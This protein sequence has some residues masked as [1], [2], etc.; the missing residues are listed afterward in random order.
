[1][2]NRFVNLFDGENWPKRCVGH[3]SFEWGSKYIY[4]SAPGSR[5]ISHGGVKDLNRENIKGFDVRAFL[6]GPCP[7]P[8]KTRIL[9]NKENTENVNKSNEPGKAAAGP[10]TVIYTDTVYKK[11]SRSACGA[12]R[13]RK[14]AIY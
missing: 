7:R 14:G 8:E 12:Y 1:M 5:G 6:R 2:T 13:R 4:S 3:E 9:M 10:L 11:R